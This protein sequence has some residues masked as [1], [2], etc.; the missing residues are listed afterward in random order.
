[1]NERGWNTKNVFNVIDIPVCSA[2]QKHHFSL[3]KSQGLRDVW[4]L[5]SPGKKN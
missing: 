2:Q 1:M 4:I 3:V 5:K